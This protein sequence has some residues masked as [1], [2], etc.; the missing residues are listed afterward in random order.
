MAKEKNASKRREIKAIKKKIVPILRDNGVVKASVFGSY[1]R[2]EQKKKSDVD[3]LVK[4][5]G[6]KSLLNLA[7]LE[8][9]IEKRLR[10]KADVLTYNSIHPL[11][12]E[13]IL[14]DEVRIL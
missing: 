11:L 13:H 14:K 10:K 3:I 12:R 8:I 9:K 6:R 4:F 2:G 5:K 1:A 7:G